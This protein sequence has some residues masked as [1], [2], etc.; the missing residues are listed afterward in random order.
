MDESATKLPGTPATLNCVTARVAPAST[1]VSLLST[2]PVAALSSA[3]VFVSAFATGAS[4]LPCTVTSISC[5]ALPSL[6]V[7]V[8]VSCT[9][10]P[11]VSDCVAASESFSA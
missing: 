1:S 3:T 6:L 11:A 5:D 2:L 10:W 7:T 8:S 9:V 4:L